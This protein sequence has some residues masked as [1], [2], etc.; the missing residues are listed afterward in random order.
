METIENALKAHTRTK[1]EEA[2]ENK[3]IVD[4]LVHEILRM[5]DFL[6]HLTENPKTPWRRM[7]IN[8][9]EF[10]LHYMLAILNGDII[11]DEI[12]KRI[13][14]KCHETDKNTRTRNG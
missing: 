8:E 2:K 7:V 12:S 5:S 14:K 11:D 1:A 9:T 3:E 10:A 13:L 6:N 4:R